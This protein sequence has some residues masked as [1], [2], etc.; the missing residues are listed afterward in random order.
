MTAD[1]ADFRP[2]V[3]RFISSLPSQ[4]V[5]ARASAYGRL[6]EILERQFCDGAQDDLGRMDAERVALADAITELEAELSNKGP[7]LADRSE[8]D[9]AP[10]DDPASD[11]QHPQSPSCELRIEDGTR[12]EAIRGAHSVRAPPRAVG[13]SLVACILSALL[14][15]IGATGWWHL[16]RHGHVTVAAEG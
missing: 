1:M 3:E 14:I 11:A 13:L 7:P 5:E 9:P 8:T 4:D 15:G 6:R 2:L 10:V 16:H 12:E